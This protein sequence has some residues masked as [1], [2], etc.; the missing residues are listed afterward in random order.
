MSRLT[1]AVKR[2]KGRP[3]LFDFGVGKFNEG[4][5]VPIPASVDTARPVSQ[6]TSQPEMPKRGPGR[7]KK[8]GTTSGLAAKEALDRQRAAESEV[9]SEEG[10]SEGEESGVEE[11]D[12]EPGVGS[13]DSE[14]E[15]GHSENSDDVP[16]PGWRK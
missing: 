7:P 9:G 2:E 13:G 3:F 8:V 16:M 10:E 14:G 12:R 6:A 1:F 4:G 15:D 5:R 11:S